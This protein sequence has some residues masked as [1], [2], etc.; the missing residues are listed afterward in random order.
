MEVEPKIH[1]Q[2]KSKKMEI[3]SGSES[4]RDLK[5]QM[6]R[7]EMTEEDG[8]R[9]RKGEV[10]VEEGYRENKIKKARLQSTLVALV[11]DPILSDVPKNPTL[12]DVDTLICLELG[13]AMRISVLKLDATAFDVALMNSATVKDLKVAIKK[14]IN[15]MEQSKMG[16]R[17]ISWKHVWGN[18]CLSY[19]NDKLLDD[20]AALQDFG[21]RNNSQVHFVPYVALKDSHRHSK[22]RRHRFFHG[23]S[24][25]S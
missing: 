21:I 17:H 1:S 12:S 8:N 4:A 10:I 7:M 11:D 20:N 6:Q 22:R 25:L 14:K 2:S 23:L 18:F 16:H 9:N 3:Q 5:K 15:D 24:K 13:S 19:H